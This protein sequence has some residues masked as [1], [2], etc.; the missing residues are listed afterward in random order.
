MQ[1]NVFEPDVVLGDDTQIDF[2]GRC[3]AQVG[4]RPVDVDVGRGVGDGPDFVARRIG[5]PKAL[6]VRQFE[7]VRRGSGFVELERA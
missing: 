1:T 6:P 3:D 7:P 2:G 5:I 4:R